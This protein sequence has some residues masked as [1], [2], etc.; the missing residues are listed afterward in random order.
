MHNITL[1]IANEYSR[2][3]NLVKTKRYVENIKNQ[4][5]IPPFKQFSKSTY[6]E[7][8]SQKPLTS[9]ITNL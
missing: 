6:D 9:T 4:S 1:K 3:M 7:H 8:P 5:L 2:L